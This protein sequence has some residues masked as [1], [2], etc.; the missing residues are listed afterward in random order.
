MAARKRKETA[1]RPQRSRKAAAPKAA[2]VQELEEVGG[3]MTFDDGIV[4]GTSVVL[5][6]AVVLMFLAGGTYSS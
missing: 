3:G 1:G 4:I 6:I 5:V 2:E